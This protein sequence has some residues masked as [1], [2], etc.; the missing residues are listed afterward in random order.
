MA[1]ASSDEGS[2]ME[3]ITDNENKSTSVSLRKRNRNPKFID[4]DDL[5]E[6]QITTDMRDSKLR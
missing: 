4:S 2:D 5:A 6:A 3:V 1:E